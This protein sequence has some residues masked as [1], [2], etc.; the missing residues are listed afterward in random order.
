MSF[1][2]RNPKTI[3]FKEGFNM[4]EDNDQKDQKTGLNDS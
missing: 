4:A 3:N 2:G 1:K